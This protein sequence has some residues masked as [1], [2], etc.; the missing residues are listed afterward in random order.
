M[1]TTGRAPRVAVATSDDA[2]LGA[3]VEVSANGLAVVDEDS[4][5]LALNEAGA[6]I[7][8]LAGEG[9]PPVW[10]TLGVD[11]VQAASAVV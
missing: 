6:H 9:P 1:K 3:L 7:L 8:G 11:G 4:R 5:L 2:V 10:L